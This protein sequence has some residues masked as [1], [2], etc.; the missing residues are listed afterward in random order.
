MR[1]L[2]VDLRFTEFWYAGLPHLRQQYRHAKA[3]R[4]RQ[5]R[6]ADRLIAKSIALIGATCDRNPSV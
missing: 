6:G 5:Q 2:K 3:K 1:N 4:D